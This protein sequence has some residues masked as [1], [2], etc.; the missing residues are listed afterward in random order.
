MRVLQLDLAD[1]ASVR[2]FAEEFKKNYP[3][4]VLLINNAGVMAPPFSKTKDGFELQF[5]TNH[6]GPFALTAHLLDV[7][8]NTVGAR[9][10]N[11]ASIAHYFGKINFD[12]LAWEK[13]R[14]TD[15]RESVTA[16]SPTFISSLSLTEN[17]RKTNL[18]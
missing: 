15:W 16:N 4:L 7:L 12:D 11:M 9:V 2:R 6:L 17:S 5:G 14:Y 13:R 18:I 1:L 10:V 8:T 3:R